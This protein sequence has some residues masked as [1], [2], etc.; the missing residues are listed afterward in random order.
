MEVFI[1]IENI[2]SFVI[3]KQLITQ[4]INI[5][6]ISDFYAMQNYIVLRFFRAAVLCKIKLVIM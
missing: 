6:Y 4:T 3:N 2:I 5:L 1:I